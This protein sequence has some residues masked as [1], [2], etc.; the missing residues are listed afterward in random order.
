MC[1]PIVKYYSTY[2]SILFIVT[3]HQRLITYCLHCIWLKRVLLLIEF[4]YQSNIASC[5]HCDLNSLTFQNAHFYRSQH[6]SANRKYSLSSIT[7]Y[8]IHGR[9]NRFCKHCSFFK[10]RES[11]WRESDSLSVKLF[12]F[13]NYTFVNVRLSAY[14]QPRPCNRSQ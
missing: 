12:V 13:F 11:C 10:T 4:T 3:K 14:V 5:M 1:N 6:T 8:S 9:G 2:C 7:R